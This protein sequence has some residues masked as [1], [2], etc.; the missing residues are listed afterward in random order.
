MAAAGANS[1]KLFDVR[2]DFRELMEAKASEGSTIY[3]VDN[4]NFSNKLVFGCKGGNT[5]YLNVNSHT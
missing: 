5:Y 1:V 3:S 2:E 4:G